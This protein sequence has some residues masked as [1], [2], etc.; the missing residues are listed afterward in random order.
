MI[1][2]FPTEKI[3]KGGL[4]IMKNEKKHVYLTVDTI[5]TIIKKYNDILLPDE[6]LSFRKTIDNSFF[7]PRIKECHNVIVG[8]NVRFVTFTSNK[9]YWELEMNDKIIFR[10]LLN[11]CIEKYIEVKS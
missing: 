11:D 7:K 4:H 5:R 8:K 2:P 1:L 9:Q 6:Q 10:G 3:I